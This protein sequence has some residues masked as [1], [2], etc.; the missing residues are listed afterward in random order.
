MCKVVFNFV[1]FSKKTRIVF[2][3]SLDTIKKTRLVLQ[4][5]LINPKRLEYVFSVIR[6]VADCKNR[7]I[8]INIELVFASCRYCGLKRQ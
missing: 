4:Y 5:K 6:L 7:I 8:N 1:K 2:N 3:A